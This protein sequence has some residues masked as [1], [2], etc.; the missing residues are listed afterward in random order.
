MHCTR[1]GLV[2]P[3]SANQ[4]H[5][6]L[7]QTAPDIYWILTVYS[8]GREEAREQFISSANKF[9][10]QYL[11]FFQNC[12]PFWA[13]FKK[14]INFS[15][16]WINV[17]SV[18]DTTPLHW[19]GG[20]EIEIHKRLTTLLSQKVYI[21]WLLEILIFPHR[22]LERFTL[23]RYFDTNS[24]YSVWSVSSRGSSRHRS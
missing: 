1:F 23:E 19:R 9:P 7:T 10:T 13:F 8:W 21:D 3:P 12:L 11:K 22:Y 16:S 6:T 20:G 15:I 5:T 4:K 2:S 24:S 18:D 17:S 14:D